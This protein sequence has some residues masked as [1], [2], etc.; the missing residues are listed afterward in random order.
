MMKRGTRVTIK[1]RN[2]WVDG[3]EGIVI[4][5]TDVDHSVR[6]VAVVGK[7]RNEIVACNVAWLT[8]LPG[9]QEP[10]I[11]PTSTEEGMRGALYQLI[12]AYTFMRQPDFWALYQKLD[13]ANK[14]YVLDSFAP[15]IHEL[16]GQ[17]VEVAKRYA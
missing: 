16:I 6:D 11:A 9:D 13:D 8:E 3:C 15:S 1:A 17:I 12:L 14:Q 4:G 10:V 7:A 5:P 2:H